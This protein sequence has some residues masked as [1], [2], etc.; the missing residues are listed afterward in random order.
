[1]NLT[2]EQI[3]D[4]LHRSYTAVDGLWFM[5]VEDEY[6]FDRALEIDAEVWKIFP[7]I[8]ARKLKELTGL[9]NGIDDLYE[10]FTLKLSLDQLQYTAAKDAD[11]NGFT[12]SITQCPWLDLLRKSQRE[13]LAGKVGSRIC[14]TE[15]STWA[16]EFGPRIHFQLQSQ[17]CENADCCRLRFTA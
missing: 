15:Y 17:I 7:K 11:G 16:A 5:K 14:T 12:V 8:Q 3:I 2:S 13:H 1:M 9:E 10:C 4:Y 6:G